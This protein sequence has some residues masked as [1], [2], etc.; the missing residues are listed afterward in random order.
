MLSKHQKE[1]LQIQGKVTAEGKLVISEPPREKRDLQL[2]NGFKKLLSSGD[3]DLHPRQGALG[4]EKAFIHNVSKTKL[5]WA[6]KIG[7]IGNDGNLQRYFLPTIIRHTYLGVSGVKF[8]SLV[9]AY[10][11]FWMF[12]ETKKFEYCTSNRSV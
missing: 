2:I 9:L 7:N 10:S 11:P 3:R 8:Q 1:I 6:N 5:D 4:L 12:A